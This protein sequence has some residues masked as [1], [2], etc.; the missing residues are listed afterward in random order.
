MRA[1]SAGTKSHRLHSKE[2]ICKKFRP[3]KKCWR[4]FFRVQFILDNLIASDL[5]LGE[6]KREVRHGHIKRIVA[7]L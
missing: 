7:R 2:A 4:Y 3:G 1:R 5:K 6:N